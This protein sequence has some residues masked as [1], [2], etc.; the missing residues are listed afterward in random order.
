MTPENPIKTVTFISAGHIPDK[1]PSPDKPE[2]AFIGRSNVGKS[3][4]LNMITGRKSLARVSVSPGKTQSINHYLVNDSWYLVDLPGYGFAKVSKTM[5]EQWNDFSCKYLI[6]RPNLM[7]LFQL[8]DCRIEPQAIDLSFSNFLG[9]EKIP[10]VLAFTK[11]D[12]V[13]TNILN[14]N[15]SAYCREMSK[16]WEE[17][18]RQFI[19]SSNNKKGREEL[20]AFIQQTNLLFNCQGR[21]P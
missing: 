18:P 14:K 15:I 2:Y 13:T 8:I 11:S 7:C 5:R 3:S 19:T 1:C 10:F 12:K 16:T 20:L 9:K 21:N 4:L 17:L 6:E